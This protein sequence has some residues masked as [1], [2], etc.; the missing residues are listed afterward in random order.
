MAR[1]KNTDRAEARR[2]YREQQRAETETPESGLEAE[3]IAAPLPTATGSMRSAMR[4]PNIR[5]DLRIVPGMMLRTRKLWIPVVALLVAFLLAVALESGAFATLPDGVVQAAAIY[6]QLTLPPTALFVFF[7]G[8]FLAPRASYLVGALLGL[9]DG[10][11]W[12]LLFLIVPNAQIEDPSRATGPGDFLSII[13][14][15]VLIGTA[16]GGF[17][18]WY[19]NFL[20]SSQERA[21]INRIQRDQEAKVKAKEKEKADREAQRKAAAEARAAGSGK[22][23]PPAS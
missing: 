3:A 4:M 6:V 16:A 9:L 12:S 13:F 19:R 11:L 7:L 18:A 10:I 20:R 14:L 23:T 22:G 8:G 21:R 5:E 2:R 15:A 1:A 17:A